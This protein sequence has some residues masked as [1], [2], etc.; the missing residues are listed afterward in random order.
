[1]KEDKMNATSYAI[2]MWSKVTFIINITMVIVVAFVTFSVLYNFTS[3]VN[4][5]CFNYQVSSNYD[6]CMMQ[7]GFLLFPILLIGVIAAGILTLLNDEF[8]LPK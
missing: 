3:D 6:D 1:M 2:N 4:S 8:N 5:K 7:Q